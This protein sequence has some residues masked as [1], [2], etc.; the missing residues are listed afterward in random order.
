NLSGSIDLTGFGTGKPNKKRH[1]PK[2]TEHGDMRYV[3][4]LFLCAFSKR[5]REGYWMVCVCVCVCVLAK[6]PT[7]PN[8][9]WQYFQHSFYQQHNSFRSF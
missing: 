3:K 9:F 1:V 2:K 7:P 8:I 4:Y 5:G 6:Y